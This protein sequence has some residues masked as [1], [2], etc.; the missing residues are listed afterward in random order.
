MYGIQ[1]WSNKVPYSWVPGHID[2]EGNERPDELAM[3]GASN[4]NNGGYK[5]HKEPRPS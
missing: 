5:L 1:A 3:E 2:K 4:N